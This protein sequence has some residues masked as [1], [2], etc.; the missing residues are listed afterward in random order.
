[1]VT[2]N[3]YSV[4]LTELKRTLLRA[5]LVIIDMALLFMLYIIAS[6][7]TEATFTDVLKPLPMTSYYEKTPCLPTTTILATIKLGK[8]TGPPIICWFSKRIYIRHYLLTTTTSQQVY[9]IPQ[10]C[11]ILRTILYYSIVQYTVHNVYAIQCTVFAIVTLFFLVVDIHQGSWSSDN[12]HHKFASRS[13]CMLWFL[14]HMHMYLYLLIYIQIYTYG[15]PLYGPTCQR[16][17]HRKLLFISFME[18]RFHCKRP[19]TPTVLWYCISKFTQNGLITPSRH[20]S[21]MNS[22]KY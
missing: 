19:N 16:Y 9:S 15:D 21:S 6:L 2:G 14:G 8:V 20:I 4:T 17:I 12:V 3:G 1:M 5:I 18:A 22:N 7:L 13:M 10:Y 11:I